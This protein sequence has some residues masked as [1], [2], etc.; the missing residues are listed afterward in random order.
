MSAVALLALANGS[1]LENNCAC[2][3]GGVVVN[4]Q[5]VSPRSVDELYI[6]WLWKRERVGG[7]KGR[8]DGRTEAGGGGRA[9]ERRGGSLGSGKYRGGVNWARGDDI[10]R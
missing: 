10:E 7:W 4:L 3:S 1:V 2:S 6:L 5:L 8:T 9:R